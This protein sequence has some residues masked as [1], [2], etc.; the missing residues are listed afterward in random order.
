MLVFPNLSQIVIIIL[1]HARLSGFCE[2]MH[3][4]PSASIWLVIHESPVALGSMPEAGM[5]GVG[6][7]K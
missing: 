7:D 6:D 2:Y 3:F 4:V 1:S 5:A